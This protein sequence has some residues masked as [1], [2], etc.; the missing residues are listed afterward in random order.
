MLA[1]GIAPFAA[2]RVI[3][4]DGGGALACPFREATGLPCPL[5]GATRAFALATRG[6]AAFLQYNAVAVA[7]AAVM[8]V[9]GA[10]GLLLA[11]LRPLPARRMAAHLGRGRTL[12]ALAL[13]GAALAWVWT[14][15]HAAAITDT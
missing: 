9:A 3:P 15:T 8:V 12:L 1:A 14:L 7:G 4:P 6:D 2:G 11:A 5:C 13:G 10:A